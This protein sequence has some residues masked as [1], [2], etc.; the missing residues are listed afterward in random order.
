LQNIFVPHCR[1]RRPINYSLYFT[2]NSAKIGL[3]WTICTINERNFIVTIISLNKGIIKIFFFWRIYLSCKSNSVCKSSIVL[4]WNWFQ[5]YSTHGI[6][7]FLPYYI[8]IFTISQVLIAIFLLFLRI[9][10][11]N[12][13][14]RIFLWFDHI[15]SL[16]KLKAKNKYNGHRKWVALQIKLYNH[17]YNLYCGLLIWEH[18]VLC[19]ITLRN[20]GVKSKS[21]P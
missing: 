16:K 13:K 12:T 17:Q 9:F 21:S 2:H 10:D 8:I 6:S 11:N 20:R 5:D 4:C 3:T 14:F 18:P 15:N 1:N 19:V 7:L